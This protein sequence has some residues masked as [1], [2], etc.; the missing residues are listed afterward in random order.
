M[1]VVADDTNVLVLL[2]YHASQRQQSEVFFRPE[3]KLTAV[4]EGLCWAI[5]KPRS[6]IKPLYGDL[7]DLLVLHSTSG[8]DTISHVHGVDKATA[9][10]L[11]CTRPEM[12]DITIS[13]W[14]PVHLV[15]K[16]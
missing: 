16:L 8:C 2:L 4:K 14:T 15:T 6:L 13:S 7:G 5:K 3:P 1:I 9:V 11:F 10:K 12:S